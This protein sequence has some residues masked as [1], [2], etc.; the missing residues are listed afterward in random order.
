MLLLVGLLL[1]LVCLA[2]QAAAA[3]AGIRWFDKVNARPLLTRAR[4][5]SFYR[6]SGVMLV[7]ALGILAQMT[8]WALLYWGAGAMPD[9]ETALYFSGVTFT[10]L[11]YGDIVLKSHIR[12]LAPIEAMTGLLMFAIATAALIA[13][14]QRL[15]ANKDS[16]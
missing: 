3:V 7:I 2:L 10:S 6:V 4:W 1:M 11:G 15:A 9:F 16:P 12:L 13:V 14:I 5:R 8:A